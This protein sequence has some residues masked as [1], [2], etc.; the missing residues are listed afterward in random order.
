MVNDFHNVALKCATYQ[1]SKSTFHQ[2]LYTLL[3]I[4][5]DPWEDVGMDLILGL[6]RAQRGVWFIYCY[7]WPVL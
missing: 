5:N 1:R 4:L 6:P 7:G 3:P 2:G